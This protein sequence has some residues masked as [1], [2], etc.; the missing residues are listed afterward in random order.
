MTFCVISKEKYR[1]LTER[2][3]KFLLKFV[4]EFSLSVVYNWINT[5]FRFI[6]QDYVKGTPLYVSL[7]SSKNVF[8]I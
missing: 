3:V 1:G 8:I 5:K 7:N 2:I 6:R 4:P